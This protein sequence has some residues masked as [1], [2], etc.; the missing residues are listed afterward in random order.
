MGLRLRQLGGVREFAY[1][2]QDIIGE[3]HGLNEVY[4][5][6]WNQFSTEVAKISF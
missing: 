6:K 1:D 5:I 2:L 4:K 3:F